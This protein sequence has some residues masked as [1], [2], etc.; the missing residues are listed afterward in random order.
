MVTRESLEEYVKGKPFKLSEHTDNIIKAINRRDGNCPCRTEDTPCPC[1]T[2]EQ[3][4]EADGKCHCNL[5]IQ[6]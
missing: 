5:F 6:A 4:V 2:H 1:P 3:E